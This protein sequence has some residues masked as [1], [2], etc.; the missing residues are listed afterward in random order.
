MTITNNY[1]WTPFSGSDTLLTG[2]KAKWPGFSAARRRDSHNP[3][4]GTLH[5]VVHRNTERQVNKY[6]IP[7]YNT[8]FSIPFVLSMFSER[9][10]DFG[11]H[12]FV[13][14]ISSTAS[15][16]LS[17]LISFRLILAGTLERVIVHCI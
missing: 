9:A 17:L 16:V 2:S 12:L 15:S 14:G 1:R 6:P 4:Q 10:F 7:A 8:L 5:G 3:L 13:Y 11:C